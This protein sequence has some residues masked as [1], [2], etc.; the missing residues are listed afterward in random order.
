MKVT[1]FDHNGS[2]RHV[3][4]YFWTSTDKDSD[5]F[6]C[7][8]SEIERVIRFGMKAKPVPH[9]T[10]FGHS[11]MTVHADG[12][13]M[14]IAEQWLR[15]RVQNFSKKSYRYVEAEPAFYEI[16]PEDMR[17]QVG[18]PGHYTFEPMPGLEATACADILRDAYADAW[19]H[20]RRLRERNLC[21]EQARF[22]LSMGL[23]T[24]MYASADLRGW[25]NFC[26]QRNDSHAQV[27]VQRCAEQI[28]PILDSL[29][30]ITMR[31]WRE[32]GRRIV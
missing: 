13:P 9:A 20:Y 30:P 5:A 27:E 6:E 31:L 22:A 14:P 4:A 32:C 17:C 8:E 1:L 3:A 18:R 10:P 15:H 2:D 19:M 16:P 7:P 23:M 25:L 24:R 21:N 28:E 12:L 26:V 29:Y 11:R